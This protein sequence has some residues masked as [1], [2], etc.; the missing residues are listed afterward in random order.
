MTRLGR[1]RLMV[2]GGKIQVSKPFKDFESIVP[3]DTREEFLELPLSRVYA[4]EGN[5]R[6]PVV[7]ERPLEIRVVQPKDDAELEDWEFPGTLCAPGQ[8]C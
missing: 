1:Y 4:I 2:N 6:Q 7:G 8:K 3:V 5:K